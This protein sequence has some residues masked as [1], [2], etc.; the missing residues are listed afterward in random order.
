MS[1]MPTEI[2]TSSSVMVIW[3]R[4]SGGHGDVCHGPGVLDEGLDAAE[5]L[6]EGE[7]LDALEEAEDL[8]LSAVHAEGE[9]SAE[10]GHLAPGEL[11][12]GVAFESGVKDFGDL[13]V[14]LEPVG[15]GEGV[16]VVLFHAEREGLDAAEDE[17]AVL[18]SGAASHGVLEESDLLGERGVF[19]D[20]GAA[21]DVGVSVDVFGGG[22]D[23]DVDAEVE[24]PLE[25]GGEKGVVANGEHAGLARDG[26]D[27]LEVDDVHEG[28]RGG[29]DP[30][31]AGLGSDGGADGVEVAQ[32]DE[33]H[34]DALVL[35]HVDEEAVGSAVE[36]VVDE[37]V[38]ALVEHHEDGCLGGH[39]G[40][41]GEP[42]GAVFEGGEAVFE[43]FA[44]GVS[45][46][47][48]VEGP[49]LV[50]AFKGEGG[51]LV[52]GGHDGAVGGVGALAGVDGEGL[53]AQV[54]GLRG[55]VLGLN[56]FGMQGKHLHCWVK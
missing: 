27:G 22:V 14:L 37:E 42:G 48:V 49:G 36:V 20:H 41:E 24:R 16:L 8:V 4:T 15:D 7:E 2:R 21:D 26:S 12:L 19:D 39:A 38:V 45:A 11:V 33:V 47:G 13:G 9:G 40:C 23:D 17:E 43:G 55:F 34:L 25:V 51:G 1:S 28:V 50:D 32:V 18:G 31:G 44:G 56:R 6:G 53:E 3:R 54:G 5:G 46:A 52:D 30:E 29:F 35:N 10:A